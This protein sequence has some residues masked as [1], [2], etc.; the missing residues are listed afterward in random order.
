[1]IF[2][3]IPA[4][5]AIFVD[6]NIFVY[7]FM[8]HAVFGP[9]CTDLL[10]QIEN[11][12]VTAVTSASILMDVAHRLMTVEAHMLWG[13]PFT[14]MAQRLKRHPSEVQQLSRYRQALDEIASLGFPLLPVT[15]QL[16]SQAA[17]ISRQFGLLTSDALV[18]AVMRDHG[19][20]HL[21]SHDADFDRLP[22]LSRYA[23]A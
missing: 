14:A 22:G 4:G 20:I 18:A 21:A 2:S 12:Q 16:V 6:A 3:D 1:M 7:H 13:W 15:S 5:A 19:L 8:P 23:P 10:D 11:Q 9:A 17:N